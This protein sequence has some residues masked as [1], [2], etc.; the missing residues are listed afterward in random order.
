MQLP[1]RP[2]GSTTGTGRKLYGCDIET[3][4]NVAGC[5]GEG[6][7]DKCDHALDAYKNRITCVAISD[8]LFDEAV[9]RGPDLINRFNEFM[10]SPIRPELTFHKGSF[11]FKVLKVHGAFL[12]YEDWEDDSLLLLFN[13]PDKI[14]DEWM[15]DYEAKAKELNAKRKAH[16][17][18]EHRK[19]GKHSL[20]TCAPYYLGVEA[21][22]EPET[23]HDDDTY[24]IKDARYAKN[25]RDWAVE[26]LKT[27]YPLIYKFYREHHL[28][29]T[30]NLTQMEIQGVK[31]DL[32]KLEEMWTASIK[33]EDELRS[34]ISRQWANHFL[35]YI[36]KQQKEI[37]S[38]YD[39][40]RE[41]AKQKG[42]WSEK[43]AALYDRNCAKALDR[44]SDLNLDSPSQL[45]WLLT[46]RL[47]LDAK[48][49]DGEDSTGAQV[50]EILSV[51]NPEVKV[52]LDYRSTRKLN[53]SFYPE[54]KNFAID[55]IIHT[56]YKSAFARTGRLSCEMPNLQQVPAA[57][58]QLFIAR[59]GKKLN[60]K[61]VSG[62]EPTVLAYYTEDE[63]LC[64]LLINGGNFH[65]TNVV[66]MFQLEIDPRDVKRL[67]PKYREVAKTVGLAIL[68]GAGANR[69][70]Q[71]LQ[72]EGLH[73]YT[74][75][76][77]Q[78]MVYRV[79]EKYKGVWKFKTELDKEL[80]QGALIYNLLGRPI[81]FSDPSEVYMKGL[82]RL[83]QGSASDLVL[84]AALEIRQHGL[85]PLLLVHDEVVTEVPDD[86]V[87]EADGIITHLMTKTKL[88][89]KYGLIPIKV[90]GKTGREWAK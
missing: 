46:E 73:Q 84:Q 4:C 2:A 29:W 20:K 62:I 41:A 39:A 8:G 71:T 45:H 56:N 85:E 70:Y 69:V 88:Q 32:H 18:T 31:L 79:R 40:M 50:L 11:D 59:W 5:P 61:D 52:L 35:A 26:H 38:R 63:E 65:D 9:F 67:Y 75:K 82:N 54:Y 66:E 51:N 43:I 30:K 78:R 44:V 89:T 1:T 15:A 64:K 55:G 17:H 23:G 47:G 19:A 7:S 48:N 49:L 37:Y 81:Q 14:P 72:L 3:A 22:W 13:N 86:L 53:T 87:E 80:E 21:F 57:L 42:R 28:P 16:K 6:R 58:H 27:K 90:E 77:A 68:Y 60:D 24:V 34:Q 83:I 74:W 76:D 12:A 33:H 25:L 10:A 36:V